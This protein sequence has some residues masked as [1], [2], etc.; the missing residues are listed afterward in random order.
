[1]RDGHRRLLVRCDLG[2]LLGM[3][4]R[5][6]KRGGRPGL[7]SPTLFSQILQSIAFP[8]GLG[9]SLPKKSV[10]LLQLLVL[11]LQTLNLG[12][13]LLNSTLETRSVLKVLIVVGI[14]KSSK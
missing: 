7:L 11:L 1:M 10:L 9:E 2:F 13:E 6:T 5:G 14:T 4:F 12:L 8:L 3:I